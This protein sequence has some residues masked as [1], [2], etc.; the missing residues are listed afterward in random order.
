[1]YV[2]LDIVRKLDDLIRADLQ[3]LRDSYFQYLLWASAVVAI[4]VLLEGPEVIHEARS[5]L[6]N[7][8]IGTIVHAQK[9]ITAVALIGWILVVLGVG[10]EGVAEGYVSRTDGTLQTFNEI[11]LAD[12]QRQAAA[13]EEESAYAIVRASKADLNRVE[14]QAKILG[15]F[16]PRTLSKEQLHRIKSK[17]AKLPNIKVDVYTFALGNPWSEADTEES[18]KLAMQ[19]LGIC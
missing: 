6:R 10:G 19:L 13:A 12:A 7:S 9:W 4:G 8:S 14:L 5:L 1:M 18:K 3:A 15:I 17:L 11:L 16:G 2:S